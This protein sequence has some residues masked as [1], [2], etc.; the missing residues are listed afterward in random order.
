MS[1]LVLGSLNADLV[2]YVDRFP[3]PGETV[4]GKGFEVHPGGKGL[5]QATAAARCGASVSMC[6]ALGDDEYGGF[7]QAQLAREGINSRGIAVTNYPTGR[8]II[9]VES[10]G[11][12][13]IIV[14]PGANSQLALGTVISVI[15][16]LKPRVILAQL[17]T[18]LEVTI[19]A[20]EYA[21]ERGIFTLLNPAPYQPLPEGLGPLVDLLIPNEYE[22]HLLTGVEITTIDDAY[23]A[24][25]ILVERGYKEVI[26]T[27]GD[28]G[29]ILVN[30]NVR[31]HLSPFEVVAIDTTAA[32]DAFCGALAANLDRGSSILESL[33]YA[34]AAG[35]LATT[36]LGAVTSL[37]FHEAISKFENN[38]DR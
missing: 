3:L 22:A 8:A 17:E 33:S 36:A 13:R 25:E 24:A 12:N 11:K 35:A 28:R 10:S 19:G 32:G 31:R 20:F 1:V 29:A 21:R 23:R 37:P 34:S 14:I 5:N 2:T 7:L 6:G 26:V 27:L 16:E 4:M 9:E 38:R 18:P 30:L 15:D